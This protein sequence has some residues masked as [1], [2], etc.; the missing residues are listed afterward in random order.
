M[1]SE[2]T[3]EVCALGTRKRDKDRSST[4]NSCVRQLL[5]VLGA[6]DA[7]VL[8]SLKERGLSQGRQQQGAG[9]SSRQTP[10]RSRPEESER[11]EDTPSA[12]AAY[13]HTPIPARTCI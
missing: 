8:I 2:L 11:R 4:R 5:V 3:R 1:R 12:E 13:A 9:H 7:L 6:L 10:A